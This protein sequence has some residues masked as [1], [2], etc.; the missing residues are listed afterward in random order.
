MFSASWSKLKNSGDRHG[1]GRASDGIM[2]DFEFISSPQLVAAW[3]PYNIRR[4]LP[5]SLRPAHSS[6]THHQFRR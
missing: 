1:E 5:D 2:R 6:H 4:V 3:H